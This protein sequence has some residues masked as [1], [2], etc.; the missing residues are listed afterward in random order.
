MIGVNSIDKVRATLR[1]AS[2]L[3]HSDNKRVSGFGTS[4]LRPNPR[5]ARTSDTRQPLGVIA[6]RFKKRYKGDTKD[7]TNNK[8]PL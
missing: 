7:E 8:T 3:T 5:Y 1:F 2:V 6:V 4:C